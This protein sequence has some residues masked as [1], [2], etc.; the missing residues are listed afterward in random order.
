M[1]CVVLTLGTVP[2][3]TELSELFP[4]TFKVPLVS[5]LVPYSL[6]EIC[7]TAVVSAEVVPVRVTS[8]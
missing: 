5:R 3:R 2:A 4:S 7:A 8:L 1:G 6:P